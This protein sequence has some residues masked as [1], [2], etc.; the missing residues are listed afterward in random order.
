MFSLRTRRAAF[1]VA[2]RPFARGNA[3]SALKPRWQVGSRSPP[4][5]YTLVY[6][7]APD[8]PWMQLLS[9]LWCRTRAEILSF[10]IFMRMFS[11][12]LTSGLGGRCGAGRSVVLC[13]YARHLRQIYS[14][15]CLRSRGIRIEYALVCAIPSIIGLC[16][17]TY[18]PTLILCVFFFC[19][20]YASESSSKKIK[21]DVRATYRGC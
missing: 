9:L 19:F 18:C 2:W 8:R 6:F 3:H 1:V 20:V 5:L 10:S 12:G 16:R 11:L 17:N 13:A 21:I 4:L 15:S 14:A 7:T